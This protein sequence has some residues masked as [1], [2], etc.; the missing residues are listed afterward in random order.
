MPAF[1]RRKTPLTT[2]CIAEV[3]GM[4]VSISALGRTRMPMEKVKALVN[5]AASRLP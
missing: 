1:Q 3:K 5:S 2:A 4:L